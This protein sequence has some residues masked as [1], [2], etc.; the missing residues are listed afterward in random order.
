MGR[1]TRSF[2]V[3]THSRNDDTI[4]TDTRAGFVVV[5]EPLE[6]HAGGQQLVRLMRSPGNDLELVHG[7]LFSRGLITAQQQV[8]SARYCA[9]A[10]GPNGENSYNVVEVDL[11][12]A[13]EEAVS[14][15][16]PVELSP[17][18][19]YRVP[20]Q[21]AEL[22]KPFRRLSHVHTAGAFDHEGGLQEGFADINATNAV[23]KVVGSLVLEGNGHMAE[24]FLG[25]TADVDQSLV[26][27]V[28][29][30]GFTG[31]ITLG[32]VSSAAVET[33]RESDFT[34]VGKCSPERFSVY[35]GSA[36]R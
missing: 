1:I 2:A 16:A 18:A 35:A 31:L 28:R 14:S 5:E 22:A 27:L 32:E 15:A 26:H 4:T 34:L 9:G 30:A 33:A 12:A 8:S 24:L 10:T 29:N 19:I 6:I 20:G 7:W 25:T 3:T 36:R 21:L 17:H 13:P 23:D 11:V